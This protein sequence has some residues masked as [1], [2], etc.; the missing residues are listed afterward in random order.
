M[1]AVSPNYDITKL[2][3][4]KIEDKIDVFADQM[5]GWLLAHA[6]ALASRDYP[7]SQHTGFAILSLI[8]S[9]FEAIASFLEGESS[10]YKSAKFFG[11]GFRDV[12]PEFES[13]VVATGATDVDA[14]LKRLSDAYYREV[15]CG[16]FHEAMVRAGTV[17]VKGA[18]HTLQV[19]ED[20]S[21]KKLQFE[22]DPFSLLNRVQAHF[23][24]YVSKLRSGAGT[25]LRTKFERE[26]DRRTSP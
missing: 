19:R 21:T 12:F 18:S 2:K 11:I 24:S 13:Q 8:G 26:W 20:A 10:E 25:Q 22:I 5:N 7:T 15:R 1:F 9:Y 3:S 4:G 17:I 14:E 23:D 16:L 6:H